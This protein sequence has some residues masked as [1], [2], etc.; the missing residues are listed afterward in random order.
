MKILLAEDNRELASA[1]VQVLAIAKYDPSV[2]YDGVFALEKLKEAD[3]DLLI[4]DVMMPR[5]D[6]FA[7]V[8]KLRDLG[9]NIPILMLT[10]RSE[11]DDKVLALDNGADDYLTKPFEVKE[12]L[13]RIRALLRRKETVVKEAHRFG[14]ISLDYDSFELVSN[15]K[16]AHLTNKEYLLLESLIAHH[17]TLLSTERLMESV[18]DYDSEADISVVW[19]YITSLRRKLEGVDSKVS[20]KAVRGQGYRLEETK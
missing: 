14:D 4:C 9:S 13:A 17:D 5:L 11:I 8:K 10:A 2:A 19:A 12:L 15:G 18:W 16:R 6:G 1:I 20:I 3:Y 7:L